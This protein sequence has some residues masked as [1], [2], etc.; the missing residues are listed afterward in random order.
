MVGVRPEQLEYEVIVY[1]EEL[2]EYEDA[3][4]PE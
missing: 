2:V 3:E 1:D 4:L